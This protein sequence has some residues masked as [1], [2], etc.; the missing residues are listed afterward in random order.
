[1]TCVIAVAFVST[2]TAPARAQTTQ[3]ES[4]AGVRPV[5]RP[6]ASQ[7]STLTEKTNAP[8]AATST[9][10]NGIKEAPKHFLFDQVGIWTSPSRIRLRD[11]AWLVPLGGVAAGLFAT[12]SDVSRH[13]NN[14][15]ST[16]LHYRHLS[17]YG[18]GAM[19]GTGAGLYLFGLADHNEHQRETGFL[20][21]EA[22][23]D[24]LAVTEAV[25]YAAARER[26]FTDNA[27]GSFWEGGDSFPSEHATAA[28]AIAGVIAHEYPGPIPQ[29]AAYG[30]ATA[31]SASRI[32]AR[33]HFPSD[34]LVGSAIGW[35]V[36]EYVYKQHHD[37]DLGGS[38]WRFP[39]FLPEWRQ[40]DA[41]F[42]GSPYVPMDSWIYPALARLAAMGYIHSDIEG[43]RPWT[44]ME[45]ARLVQEAQDSVGEFPEQNSSGADRIYDALRN[46]FSAEL[47]LLGGGNN[48][49][50][51]AESVY[52]RVTGISGQPLRDGYDFGQ[53][54]INDDGRPYAEGVN[55]VT[56]AS[57]WASAGPFIGY[58][59]GEYQ[60]APASPSLPNTA[61]QAIAQEEGIPVAP[62]A[63]STHMI[64]QFDML[65]GYAGM[66]LD[67]WQ[68]TFG[69]QEQWWGPDAGGP[70]IFS[71]NAE[72]LEML[73]IN[74]TTPVTLPGFLHVL[75]PTRADF[76]LGR[77]GGYHWVFDQNTG[78]T[79]SW[80]QSLGDQPF[81]EGEKLSVKPS[82]NL[83]FGFSATR[84]FA[85]A[86]VPFTPH[87]F[88][89]AIFSFG[90]ANP[91]TSGDPGDARGEFDFT[92]RIPGVRNWLT[93]YGDGFT[94]DEPSPLW[95]AFDKSAFDA[96]IYLPRIPKIPKLDFRA[97]GIFTDNPNSN[98]VLQHGFFYWNDRYRSG[99]TNDGNLLASWIGRQGQGAQAWATYWL[100]GRDKLQLN[101]R[102]Q[103][104]SHEFV[105]FGGTVTDGGISADFYLR[106][107]FSV[108]AALQYERW[109][110]PV[111]APT[112]QANFSTS[113][114]LTFWPGRLAA[115]TAALSEAGGTALE[116]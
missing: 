62:L 75:G 95:G 108:T 74:R 70:M 85:G 55:D 25:K 1:M 30:L 82:E 101:F 21:G 89:Q 64:N 40:L 86:G 114:Q 71:T 57:G 60:R 49:Q 41:S 73:E 47:A 48:E 37:Y 90:N 67:N 97:E 9:D 96:G 12:D 68:I 34:V 102:H 107:R 24:S 72:P 91:G 4:S 78:F 79:G 98:P 6:R 17:D 22:A 3:S 66:Q 93:F 31:I 52:S 112:A 38:G 88:F 110:F 2:G 23:I 27:N 33:Q 11:T 94:D 16:L 13:L 113:V 43:M 115:N 76:I 80:T 39:R 83:E 99:Y 19:A 18:I 111:I 44:R 50:V 14:T 26:P 36:G 46:E 103:K 59:R 106:S 116:P 100:S 92:Y 10:Q 29:I 15:P 77:L 109:N 61:L 45:C 69:K 87:K 81:I 105:P 84:L 51:R 32:T 8:R 35:L 7:D 53:T 104:V 28:W 65:D 63:T 56:G 58:I 20:A 42:M 54:V 5:P